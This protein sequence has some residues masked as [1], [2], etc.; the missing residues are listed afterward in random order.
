MEAK[1]EGRGSKGSETN[2]IEEDEGR[3]EGED[4]DGKEGEGEGIE[5]A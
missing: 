5:D 3:T 4:E 1:E 2:G